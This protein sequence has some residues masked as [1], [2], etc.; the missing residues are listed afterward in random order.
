M[1]GNFYA[2]NLLNS[3]HLLD[4]EDL[5]NV[6]NVEVAP[7]M[8]IISTEKNGT[9]CLNCSMLKIHKCVSFS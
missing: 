7:L 9:N 4:C 1:R 2:I 3:S 8:L 5:V 6:N